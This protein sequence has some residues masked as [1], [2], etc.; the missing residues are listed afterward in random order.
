MKTIEMTRPFK[1]KAGYTRILLIE[2]DEH[3]IK[4]RMSFCYPA[5]Q[6]G[7]F[8]EYVQNSYEMTR[9]EANREWA[10]NKKFGFTSKEI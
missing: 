8:V 7:K 6:A 5:V 3:H 4:Y 9:A 1:T 10:R 2:K